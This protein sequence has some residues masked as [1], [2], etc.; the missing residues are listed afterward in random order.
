M[1]QNSRGNR[2]IHC[3]ASELTSSMTFDSL[4][5][6]AI[7]GW[8]DVLI[9]VASTH[10]ASRTATAWSNDPITESTRRTE[11]VRMLLRAARPSTMPEI[12]PTMT[13]ATSRSTPATSRHR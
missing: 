8:A 6:P 13:S 2:C 12:S 9:G 1:S 3:G 7:W 10:A 5:A 11:R 4:T